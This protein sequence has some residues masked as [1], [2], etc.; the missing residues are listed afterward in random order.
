MATIHRLLE[1]RRAAK[2]RKPLFVVK[3][4]HYKGGRIKKRWRWANGCHSK[5]RQQHSGRPAVPTPGYG[6]PRAVYGLDRCGLEIVLVCNV[7]DL[8]KLDAKTEGALISS[9]VGARKRVA[10][11]TYA[12]ERKIKILNVKDVAGSRDKIT[13]SV[14]ARAKK[15]KSRRAVKLS[16]QEEKKQK[17]AEKEKKDKE[18]A[19]K[20][21]GEESVEDKIAL[22][23][24]KKKEEQEVAEKT[25]TKK[26]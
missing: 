13:E 22:A 4:S 20:S 24:E 21:S 11:L 10:L 23:E 25:I 3:E 7:N 1:I 26:H 5:V 12:L 18:E 14:A 2:R 8:A 16:K 17:A 19:K 6:S 9:G 15:R